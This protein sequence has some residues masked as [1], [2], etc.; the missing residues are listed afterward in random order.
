MIRYYV[1]PIVGTGLP[2]DSYRPKV[3][4]YPHRSTAPAILDDGTGK[5]AKT[6]CIVKVEADDFTA[7][8]ADP[9]CEDIL[10]KI[11]DALGVNATKAQ[12]ISW[13]KTHTVR[14]LSATRRN[15]IDSRLTRL[16][17][18]TSGITLNTTLWDVVLL[19]FRAQEPVNN[20]QDLG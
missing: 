19:V 2:G 7:I 1:C 8:D 12:I 14:D 9:E 11:T 16:G 17:I 20:L 15:R 13:L 10:E 5:P 4:D 18:D 3:Q 6:W